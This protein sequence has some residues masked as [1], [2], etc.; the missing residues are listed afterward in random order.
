MRILG[1]VVG[2]EALIMP[3]GQAQAPERRPI[4]SKLVGHNSAGRET[5]PLLQ[6]SHQSCCR[7]GIAS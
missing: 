5:L 4:G 1:P 2:S 6:L 7:F 3:G